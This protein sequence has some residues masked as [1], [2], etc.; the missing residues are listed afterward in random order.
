M[1]SAPLNYLITQE[2]HPLSKWKGEYTY[3]F[4][5][6]VSSNQCNSPRPYPSVFSL[7]CPCSIPLHLLFPSLLF[8]TRHPSVTR[9]QQSLV[10]LTLCGLGRLWKQVQSA[11]NPFLPPPSP[12]FIK[13]IQSLIREEKEK[14]KATVGSSPSGLP[15]FT[16]SNSCFTKDLFFFS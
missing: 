14:D 16:T 13:L 6:N 10:F 8:T 9:T 5:L 7:Y 11:P 3:S 12:S 15:L 2:D 1:L 4:R